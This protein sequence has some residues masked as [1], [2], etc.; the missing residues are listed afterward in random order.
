MSI[1]EEICLKKSS[2][3]EE[4]KKDTTLSELKDI[5]D[6]IEAP[7]DFSE[8]L[9]SNSANDEIALIAEVKK[10]SPSRSVI[11]SNFNPAE[12]A[13]IYES[14]NACCISVLT[15]IPYFQG[16]DRYIKEVKNASTLPILRKDFIID[17]YQVYESRA[18]GA[19]CILL[20][21]AA[22]EDNLA[23]ELLELARELNM[24]VLTEIHDKDELTR[25]LDIGS[26]IIGINNRN[27]KTMDVDL[28]TSYDLVKSI[29][30]NII[31]ISESGIRTNDEVYSLKVAGF[32]AILVGSSLME[33]D[34]LD[35]AVH[36]LLNRT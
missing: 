15:D 29:P 32:N 22:L 6:S 13:R 7:R 10:A 36:K 8:A 14:N 18:I 33:Q 26:D 11:R 1:L 9:I 23:R 25:A 27:L 16:D 28:E 21:M 19:D 5:I 34:N 24:S 3:V 4:C 31:K 2:H 20:I 17:P 30:D 12:I 35:D